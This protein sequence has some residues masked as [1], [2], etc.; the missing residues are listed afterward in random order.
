M[1]TK[2]QGHKDTGTQRQRDTKTQG[3]KDTETQEGHRDT[4]GTQGHRRDT[5]TQKGHKDTGGR[6]YPQTFQE[7]LRG[8][9][10]PKGL[11][12]RRSLGRRDSKHLK[13]FS[14]TVLLTSQMLF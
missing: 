1:N 4:G 9:D 6:D 2:T 5:K 10:R 8:I 7:D 11:Y 12:K 14:T 3:H 13:Q